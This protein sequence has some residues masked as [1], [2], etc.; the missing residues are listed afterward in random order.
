MAFLVNRLDLLELG[1]VLVLEGSDGRLAQVVIENTKKGDQ[2]ILML[3]SMQS[4]T[5]KELRAGV[6]YL[7]V[8]EA[9]LKVLEQA[10][11]QCV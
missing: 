2:Q 10:L 6:H 11:G 5:P 4:V 9:N 7:D 8:M 3:N 1:A